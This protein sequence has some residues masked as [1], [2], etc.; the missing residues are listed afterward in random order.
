[1]RL[2]ILGFLTILILSAACSLFKPRTIIVHEYDKVPVTRNVNVCREL[3]DTIVVYAVFVDVAVYQPWTRFD[4]ESTQDSLV[5]AM[6]WLESEAKTRGI[7]L[8]V[9]CEYHK[10]SSKD[11]V[12]ESSAKAK[13]SKNVITGFNEKYK[14]SKVF[15]WSDA[16]AKYAGKSV[17]QQ[18]GSKIKINSVLNLNQV[19][20]NNYEK[21]NVAILFFV[22]G[23]LQ[24]DPSFSFNSENNVYAEHSIITSKN[25]SVIAHEVLHLFGA[26]DLYPN[27]T[28]PNFNFNELGSTY[29]NEIMRIQHK[30]IDKLMISPITQYFIGWQDTLDY[31]NTK[32]L[33]HKK[34]FIEY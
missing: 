6:N 10:Q 24:Q 23:Y 13:L 19:L 7:N 27:Y 20:R 29:P 4:I 28:Y 12:K 15:S 2:R 30:P 8:K 14:I 33:L 17:K 34:E 9:Q 18:A 31:K 25:V 5:K 22:N 3:S 21:E 1:M 26:V 11:F 16:I 32:M